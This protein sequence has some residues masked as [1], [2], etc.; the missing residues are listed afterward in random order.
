M[1]RGQFLVELVVDLD[2]EWREGATRRGGGHG[3]DRKSVNHFLFGHIDRQSRGVL[4]VGARRLRRRL[5]GSRRLAQD[6]AAV[7]KFS[8]DASSMLCLAALAWSFK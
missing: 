5:G 3:E 2:M 1:L 8:R 6:L 7:T 4:R